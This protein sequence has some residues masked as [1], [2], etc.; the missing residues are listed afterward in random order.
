[1]STLQT[2]EE[3]V[4]ALED[5]VFEQLRL[6]MPA[7]NGGVTRIDAETRADMDQRFD[8][9]D[10]RFEALDAKLDTILTELRDPAS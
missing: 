7:M 2:L 8:G 6:T 9:V 5:F 3:R 4:I 10:Q 1:M